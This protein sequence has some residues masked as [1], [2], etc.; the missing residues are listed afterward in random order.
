MSETTGPFDSE[1]GFRAAVDLTLAA[2]QR[3]IRIFDRDL[4][5]L[6]LED[7]AHV[8]LL[9]R[10]LAAG[11]DHRLR[12]VLHDT[13]PLEK[14]SPRL[15]NLLREFS[16]C[17]EVRKTPAHLAGLGDCWLL[18]DQAHGAIRFHVDQARGKCLVASPAEIRPWWQRFDDLWEASEACSPGAVTGL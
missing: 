3:E 17:V 14:R 2:A 16:H 7:S 1:A 4:T 6:G 8:A 13:A 11:V 18:A 5:R 9:G 10:F 12:I 15:L